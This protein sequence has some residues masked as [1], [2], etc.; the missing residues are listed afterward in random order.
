MKKP[1]KAPAIA[2]QAPRFFHGAMVPAVLSKFRPRRDQKTGAKYLYLTWS[3][4]LKTGLVLA[5]DEVIQTAYEQVDTRERQTD[6]LELE[7]EYRA[8][9]LEVYD[10]PD[11]PEP[12]LQLPCVDIG[13][14]A[15]RRESDD[16]YPHFT[17]KVFYS[18]DA[19]H[20]AV[21]HWSDQFWLKL[22]PS[23]RS[24]GE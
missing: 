21:D 24:L 12:H 6:G 8:F 19:G 20:F 7:L 4:L 13:A 9:R 15:L 11:K 16:V 23:N 1:E 3:V 5:R 2:P 14:V 10:F 17:A 22:R 18:K